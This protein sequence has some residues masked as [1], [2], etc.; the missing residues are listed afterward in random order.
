MNENWDDF[1]RFSSKLGIDLDQSQLE[2]FENY[3]AVI[4]EWNKRVN[5]VSR[6]DQHRLVG[7]HFVDSLASLSL[8]PREGIVCDLGSGAG[9]PGIP[10]KIA[11]NALA[12]HLVESV[13]KKCRFLETAVS[14]LGLKN[15][16]VV[17]RRAE[18]IDALQVD[19]VVA[20]LVGTVKDLVPVAFRLLR[21]GCRLLVY[22]TASA[23]EE[24]KQ[25]QKVLIRHNG[26]V[27]TI[28]SI[29]LPGTD[30][31]RKI[32]SIIKS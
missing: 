4:L 12:L 24:I 21:P 16:V 1:L 27:E 25:A 22:K 31:V 9:L 3:R 23:E 5:L 20:R 19:V 11:R 8:L 30:I 28:R 15:A 7:Y 32:V 6:K 29:P 18:D 26:R 13:Q 2:L 14:F 17:H 10:L